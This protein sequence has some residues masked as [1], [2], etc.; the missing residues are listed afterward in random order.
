M[1]V[2]STVHESSCRG[3]GVTRENE[4]HHVGEDLSSIVEENQEE[5]NESNAKS[6]K[7]L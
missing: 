1:L 3:W 5:I 2:I 4:S 7:H 6:D